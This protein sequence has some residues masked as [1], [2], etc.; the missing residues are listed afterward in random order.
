VSAGRGDIDYDE[1]LP[2]LDA[3]GYTGAL[4]LEPEVG[5]EETAESMKWMYDRFR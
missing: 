2:A 4:S 5:P 3:L 1:L